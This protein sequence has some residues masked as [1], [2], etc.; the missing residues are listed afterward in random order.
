MKK[1]I[2]ILLT[3]ITTLI[4]IPALQA[5]TH[6]G[7]TQATRFA[8][9]FATG[10]LGDNYFNDAAYRGI[11]LAI[12]EY[13]SSID[14]DYIEPETIPEFATFQHDLA[15]TGY[16]ELIIC[17]GF[18]Q[19][20]ALNESARDYPDQDWAI[21]D[22][23]L[24]VPNVQVFTFKEHEGSF[25][26]GALAAMVTQTDKI[27]FLGGMDLYL[28]NKF[29]YGYEQGAKY[30]NPAVNVT[31]TY[32]PVPPPACWNDPPT[33][34]VIGENF[35][36]QGIDIIYPAAGFSNH[37][38]FQAASESA[39]VYAIGVDIDQDYMYPGII[40]CS[41]LK[42]FET[43]VFTA[44]KSKMDGTWRSGIHD[45]GL[46]EDGVGISSMT[47]TQGIKE[48]QYSLNGVTKSRWEHIQDIR[49]KIIGGYIL[50]SDDN[51][52]YII[53]TPPPTTTTTN[54]KAP[55]TSEIPDTES[56]TTTPTITSNMSVVYT[57]ITLSIIVPW[58][59]YRK[60]KRNSQ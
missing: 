18:L 54:T 13:S 6:T 50:V 38:I 35:Y 34:K 30:V 16:Y 15:N 60:K 14:V 56:T 10:G 48:G 19:A 45:L 49:E 20:T 1:K 24:K 17:V 28:I 37:G 31:K 47:Y 33:A 22:E 44:I 12:T 42:K 59:R 29:G 4:F 3:I 46:I 41:M 26:V 11:E 39:G 55:S 9:I 21:I 7:S 57:V 8:I 43:A 58:L 40:L 27:G 53:T 2:K 32:M 52:W 5:V 25:L 36:T 23:Y 51:P